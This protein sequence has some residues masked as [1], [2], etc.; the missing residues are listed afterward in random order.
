MDKN[1]RKTFD[2]MTGK[3]RME[4]A[5]ELAQERARIKMDALKYLEDAM[6]SVARNRSLKDIKDGIDGLM[7][8]FTAMLK[9]ANAEDEWNRACY[10]DYLARNEKFRRAVE[11]VHGRH[12]KR[13]LLHK[14]VLTKGAK[15][16]VPVE[17]ADSCGNKAE[18]VAAFREAVRHHIGRYPSALQV[19]KAAN[20]FEV[21]MRHG[22]ERW[23]FRIDFP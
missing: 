13:I 14:C 16:Y 21:E 7:P 1:T 19:D 8:M 20:G 5:G 10:E 9:A 3:E 12:G 11:R 23:N 22:T 17:P 6:D 18:A 2:M 15:D 4:R